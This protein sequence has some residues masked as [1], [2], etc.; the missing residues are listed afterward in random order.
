MTKLFGSTR[1]I[2]Y[3]AAAIALKKTGAVAEDGTGNCHQL[4]AETLV[5]AWDSLTKNARSGLRLVEGHVFYPEAGCWS[6]HS[7]TEFGERQ[8]YVCDP[9]TLTIMDTAE[10]RAIGNIRNVHSYDYVEMLRMVTSR[11]H[12]GPFADELMEDIIEK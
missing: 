10:Y 1:D 4:A 12:T 9:Q 2:M 8:Q 7:W 3:Q 11:N 6:A 5:F